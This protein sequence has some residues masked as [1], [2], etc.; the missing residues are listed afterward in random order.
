M[1]GISGDAGIE[2]RLMNKV[3]EGEGGTSWKSS[4]ET[5]ILP[6]VKEIVSGNLLYDAGSSNPMLWD[7]GGD[8]CMPMADSCW[9]MAET[10]ATL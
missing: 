9:C 5:Y 3:E 7:K 8:I 1:Q 10:I 4:I 2:N 6:Y